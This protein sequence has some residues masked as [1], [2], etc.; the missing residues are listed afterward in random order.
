[1]N[2]STRTAGKTGWRFFAGVMIVILCAV[3]LLAGCAANHSAVQ[4]MVMF[5]AG[6]PITS[7]SYRCVV[8]A[9][10]NNDGF[11][12]FAG[13]SSEPG[14]VSV[15]YKQ[16]DANFLKPLALP[17]KG[18]IRSIDAADINGDGLKDIVCSVQRQ[19]SG[20]M[21]WLN[22]P[23]GAWEKG[24]SPVHI[25]N[26]EGI[27]L[28]DV[29]ND[30]FY[31]IVAA[32]ATADSHG[33]VQVW[34]GNGKGGWEV[35]C[36]PTINGKF[37]DVCTAD[38]NGD[39]L[40]DIAAAGWGTYGSVKVWFGDG[41]GKW[42][43]ASTVGQGEFYTITPGDINGDG[44]L[45]LMSGTYRSGV[46]VY[47][48]NGRG[49]FSKMDGP[50]MEGSFWKAFPVKVDGDDRVDLLATSIENGG[51]SCWR[52]KGAGSWG[53][54]D[55]RFP[56]EGSYFDLAEMSLVEGGTP[57]ILA[58]S[59]GEGIRPFPV[60]PETSVDVA[61][62]N[63]AGGSL[64][65]ELPDASD[66]FENEVFTTV[67]GIPEYK[68]G[69][70]DLLAIDIWV[71]E[72][73]RSDKVV[74]KPNGKISFNFVNNLYVVGMTP[75]MVEE[76]LKRQLS[77]YII[78]PQIDVTVEQ[79][80]S[81]FVTVMGP[82]SDTALDRQVGGGIKYLTGKTKLLEVLAGGGLLA[83]TADLNNI[84]IRRKNGSIVVKAD[85]FKA[86]TQ[87]DRSQDPVL[88]NEDLIFVP[89][90]AEGSSRVYVFGEV[91]K[92][93]RYSFSG[94]SMKLFDAIAQAGGPT[95][96]GRPEE[97][98]IVRGDITSPEVIAANV[99]SLVE[100]GSQAQN[101]DLVNGD[102]VYIPRSSIG[103]VKL[104]VDQIRPIFN[105][106]SMPTRSYEEIDDLN[107]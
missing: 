86:I 11:P 10:L 75:S 90:M 26:Y 25:N 57:I 78:D 15:W 94:S 107:D 41:K 54:L 47:A 34:L 37:M 44:F 81:K 104:F 46:A 89:R 70:M 7:G 45:D 106:I 59:D 73:V 87:G 65:K 24:Q 83:E 92:P 19:S 63:A 9:D 71:P 82:G 33:G 76:E 21:V 58:S 52:N 60:N 17:I 62:E 101:L 31:D 51:I 18:D 12:D 16:K 1:M 69:V 77:R 67:N 74:V 48:G 38:F 2:K 98:R 66:V 56:T 49:E 61:D 64:R 39:G 42:S 50:V 5:N 96:F 100:Q 30:G 68:I 13:G 23:E 93:G 27:E 95:I 28:A 84:Q 36:G 102:L 14:G 103:S 85:I 99:R 80:K 22:G 88:D 20:L 79:Y 8:V 29:N 72:G 4:P 55:D 105:L 6:T 97:T 40:L 32:N 91:N 53:R 35:E 3:A 43:P